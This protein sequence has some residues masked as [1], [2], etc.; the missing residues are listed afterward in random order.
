MYYTYLYTAHLDHNLFRIQ[1]TIFPSP[2]PW[3]F[4]PASLKIILILNA[5]TNAC[6]LEEIVPSSDHESFHE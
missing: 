4:N 2:K 3:A 1:G 5:N 6:I